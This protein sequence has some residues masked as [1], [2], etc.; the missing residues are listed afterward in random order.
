MNNIDRLLLE[1]NNIKQFAKGY[2]NYLSQLLKQLDTDAIAAFVEELESARRQH[3][4]IF[5]AGNGGSAATAS[6]MGNDIGLAASKVGK[7][8]AFRAFA[9]TDNVALLTAIAND[10]G[11]DNIFVNQLKVH[12]RERDM[13]IVISASG[14][15]SNLIK[16]VKWVKEKHG[17]VIG[18]LGF[19]GGKL[20]EMC[21]IVV[22][23]KAHKGEYGPVEDIHMIIDHLVTA[24]LYH[25]A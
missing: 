1:N 7:D 16:A 18:L 8:E 15:S 20:E 3:K 6:H 13:L 22:Q 23:P 25:I 19:E 5:I 11:Y 17:K 24:W 4:T 21:D 14:N 2:L 10:D 12:Y 9:L